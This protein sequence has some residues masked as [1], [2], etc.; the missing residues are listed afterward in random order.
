MEY[1]WLQRLQENILTRFNKVLR[2]VHRTTAS[3]MLSPSEQYFMRT[4]AGI[5][6]MLLQM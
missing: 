3:G 2:W 6:L 4:I 5:P 1:I